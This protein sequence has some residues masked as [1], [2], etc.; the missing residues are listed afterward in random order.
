MVTIHS[1][2]AFAMSPG[3]DASRLSQSKRLT[4]NLQNLDERYSKCNGIDVRELTIMKVQE[5]FASNRLTSL[6]LT[7]CYL[8]RISQMNS[9]LNA[10]IQV[11]PDAMRQAVE[12]DMRRNLY[13]GKRLGTEQLMLGIPV[14]IK[15]N[16]ATNDLMETTVGSLALL[17]IRPVD[18]ADV[19]KALRKAGVVILGKA[20]LSEFAQLRKFQTFVFS[21]EKH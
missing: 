19:V 17:G 16:I 6:T 3:S 11:N 1:S 13:A 4:G 7:N 14:I 5:L 21:D 18:D 15:D 2:N 9:V 12:A 10:V 8:Q 20:N